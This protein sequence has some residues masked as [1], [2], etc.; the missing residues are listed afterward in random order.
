MTKR[1]HIKSAQIEQ[2]G[3]LSH[4]VFEFSNH[5]FVVLLGLNESGKSTLSEAMA[6]IFAGRRSDVSIGRRFIGGGSVQDAVLT[7]T[8]TGN[9][10]NESFSIR[11]EFRIRK[12]T[13]GKSP[14]DPAPEFS[15]DNVAS[16][17][18]NWENRI[19]V[20]N[21]DDYAL[22]Y[23]ITGPYD[24][25]NIVEVK[26][27]LEALS[28][29][30]T[31]HKSPAKVLAIMEEV[32]IEL[33]SVSK[34]VQLLGAKKQKNRFGQL[35]AELEENSKKLDK[36]K[37]SQGEILE[38]EGK[39][40]TC[41]VEKAKKQ[42]ERKSFAANEA[43]LEAYKIALPILSEINQL[44]NELSSQPEVS[45][46]WLP[47][48]EQQI[49][50]EITAKGLM[51]AE[52]TLR[53]SQEK[54]QQEAYRIGLTDQELL[55]IEVPASKVSE[56]N[57][58]ARQ[59]DDVETRE[60]NET[61]N[62]NDQKSKL[63]QQ[64]GD[65]NQMAMELDIDLESLMRLG[66]AIPDEQ[67]FGDVVRNWATQ[68]QT[69]ATRASSLETLKSKEVS[70]LQKIEDFKA[71]PSSGLV[72]SGPSSSAVGRLGK[73]QK[74]LAVA[75][76]AVPV[77]A[78]SIDPK[79]GYVAAV[80]SAL[81]MV[82]IL[83][84]SGPGISVATTLDEGQQLDGELR[85]VGDEIEEQVRSI[86]ES[87]RNEESLSQRVVDALRSYG[88][89]GDSPLV[90]AQGIRSRLPAIGTAVRE[91]SD[92]AFEIE[93][94]NGVLS[95]LA[96]DLIRIKS[97]IAQLAVDLQLS[98]FSESLS[99][100][101]M[102]DFAEVAV[103][104]ATNQTNRDSV[105]ESRAEIE[106]IL[107]SS[108]ESMSGEAV[109]AEFQAA[110]S[111]HS[112]RAGILTKTREAKDKITY[113][114]TQQPRLVERIDNPISESE[115][116]SE[117]EVIRSDIEII[118]LAIEEQQ[119]QKFA[120]EQEV[121]QYFV[122]DDLVEVKQKAS[123]LLET[124]KSVVTEGAAWW[125]AHK[126]I[127]DIKEEVEKSSQPELVQRASGIASAITG[128]AWS[129]FILDDDQRIQVQ[130]GAVRIEQE[131]LSAGSKDLLRLAIR[132]AVAEMHREKSQ[133]ALP[134]FLD[135]PTTSIDDERAPRLFDIL[136]QFS[137]H[138]QLIMTTH[139]ERS[140]AQAEAVGAFKI[141]MK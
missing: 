24:P 76:L 126:I 44:E 90:R 107:G 50:F 20:Y 86:A 55:T 74:P 95:G 34:S 43:I 11:R 75:L 120:L 8:V 111:L 35:K 131:S 15:F 87:E 127:S 93:R 60:G 14:A 61:Q 5:Q 59:R 70:V 29:G 68:I 92:A 57:S 128:G 109:L 100:S 123:Q 45:P 118:D 36:I 10:D 133:I 7:G 110:Q 137:E 119:Q 139:D 31:V 116:A 83:R 53:S 91:Y 47:A 49:T 56:F 136:K 105:S 124:Q 138:H 98:R 40:S 77:I 26:Q 6:W 67:A 99:E 101:L 122:R 30:T 16:V 54:L 39:L 114:M 130:Q 121:A 113:Q 115:I 33:V 18:A 84:S 108:I 73:Y 25:A 9:I 89:R 28:M 140:C 85:R 42:K 63:T 13:K 12:A 72:A 17:I 2:F 65:L 51:S 38:L 23:R 62:L 66:R 27:L 78:A 32:G 88:F 141:E 104:R 69:T 37:K 94:L 112:K 82:A 1:V 79:Y 80:F 71:R 125:L 81:A 102:R 106:G 22:R 134:I 41:D 96:Q 52:E 46:K 64:S 132:L 21:G 58:L 97:G 4:R 117:L 135:D 19:G 3:M 129:G 48:I 103:L